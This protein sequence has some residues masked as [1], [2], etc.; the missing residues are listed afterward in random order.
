V[1]GPNIRR[2][3]SASESRPIRAAVRNNGLFLFFGL[4]FVLTLIAQAFAGH[5]DYNN[6]QLA[7]GLDPVSLGRYLTSATFAVDIAENWQSEYLQFLLFIWVTVWFVQ[8]GS[9]ESKEL[10]E[11][12]AESDEK[13]QVGKYATEDSPRWAR[14]SG[15]RLHLFSNSLVIAMATIFF[16]SWLAQSIAGRA[17][18]NEQLLQELSDPMTWGEYVRS[19]DFWNRTLQNWQSELL[20]V[21]S[22][23]VLAIFLRQRGSP[24]SKPVGAPHDATGVEG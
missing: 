9:P 16:I 10:D 18:H 1:T 2:G 17:A 12:G 21:A 8:K 20:A 5:A 4:L 22:M 15:W 24:E 19:A 14:A 13:Q 11:A 7:S 23:V 3:S 6:Q